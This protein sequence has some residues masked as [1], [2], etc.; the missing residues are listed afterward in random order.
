MQQRPKPPRLTKRRL[1]GLDCALSHIMTLYSDM[2]HEKGSWPEDQ[3][4][5]LSAGIDYI[6]E[7]L[8]WAK[9]RERS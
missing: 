2:R 5:D 6:Q 4:R 3:V 8:R 9:A 1:A 7:L